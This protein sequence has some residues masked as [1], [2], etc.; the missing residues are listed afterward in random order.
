MDCDLVSLPLQHLIRQR[1]MRT[2]EGTPT[3]QVDQTLQRSWIKKCSSLRRDNVKRSKTAKLCIGSQILKNAMF[4]SKPLCNEILFIKNPN[5]INKLLAQFFI[6]RQMRAWEWSLKTSTVQA[7]Y[8][9]TK[10][11][12]FYFHLS[13]YILRIKL[14]KQCRFTCGG[15]VN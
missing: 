15:K 10:F 3:S 6:R 9:I 4:R 7:Y 14:H 11:H 1:Q 13:L 12:R 5:V 2:F 8:T